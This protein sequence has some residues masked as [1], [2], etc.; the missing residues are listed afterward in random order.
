MN[1]REAFK[2][3][4]DGEKITRKDWSEE[5]YIKYSKGTNTFLVH[6]LKSEETC[7]V[8]KVSFGKEDEISF[9]YKDSHNV[10]TTLFLINDNHNELYVSEEDEMEL[11]AM[12][13]RIR[14]YGTKSG[15]CTQLGGEGC[16]FYKTGRCDESDYICEPVFLVDKSNNEIKELYKLIKE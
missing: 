2:A 5:E 15:I 12:R 1:M 6:Q 7:R 8:Y 9:V 16:I 13:W 3:L 14:E 4:L 11:D 10:S